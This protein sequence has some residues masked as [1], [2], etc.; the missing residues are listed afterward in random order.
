[1]WQFARVSFFRVFLTLTVAWCALSADAAYI[2]G[3]SYTSLTG[4]A[5]NNR[6]ASVRDGRADSLTLTN[7]YATRLVFEKNSDTLVING[8]DVALAYPVALD[9]SG[10]LISPLDLTKTVEPLVYAPLLPPKK[11]TTICLDP[12]HGGKDTG[13]QVGSHTEKVLTLLLAAELRGQLQQAGFRVVQTRTKDTTMELTERSNFANRQNADLFVCLHF[14]AFTRDPQSVQGLETYTITPVG[15][16]SSNAQGEGANHGACVGN[17]VER[18][19]LLLTYLVHRSLIK[20]VGMTDRSVRR[21]RFAVL[22]D[23]EMPAVYIEG[24]YMTHPAESKKIFD[25]GYRKRMA[26]AIVQGIIAYQKLTAPPE[27][28]KTNPA[29]PNKVPAA[30]KKK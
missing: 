4:W 24:G 25:A 28:P 20:N 26:A 30:G 10:W 29:K 6:F 14:N 1:V 23:V 18:R 22:R 2:N 11:I 13:K 7:R 9:K 27:P 21:A 16:A 17:R 12:G 15:A 8:I 5:A 3:R 19:S